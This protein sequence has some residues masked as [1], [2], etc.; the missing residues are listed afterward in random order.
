MNKRIIFWID[1]NLSYFGLAKSITE[2]LGC[3]SYA[4]FDVTDRV[5]KFFKKQDIVDFKKISFYHDH[6][7][8]YT[9]EPDMDYLKKFEDRYK[10]NLFL[11]AYNERSLYHFN[12]F[13]KF[14]SRS[15]FGRS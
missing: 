1:N 5:K 15:S 7:N 13:Y 12:K 3:D 4:I 8:D 10:I 6:I 9:S 2:S 11:L 14:I